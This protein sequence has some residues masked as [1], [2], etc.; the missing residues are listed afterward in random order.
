MFG[1]LGALPCEEGKMCDG[2]STSVVRMFVTCNL[3]SASRA[4]ARPSLSHQSSLSSSA[5]RTLLLTRL[6]PPIHE[7]AVSIFLLSHLIACHAP[8]VSRE[9]S[10]CS[11]RI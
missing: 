10:M 1:P 4:V 2:F 8:S 7:A 9:P 6:A 11:A 5:R 3:S